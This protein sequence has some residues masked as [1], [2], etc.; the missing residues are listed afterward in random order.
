MAPAACTYFLRTNAK[1]TWR[2]KNVFVAASY[3]R[4]ITHLPYKV[5]SFA[6]YHH[7]KTL[8]IHIFFFTLHIFFLFSPYLT[9]SRVQ[10]A[11]MQEFVDTSPH[12]RRM[13]TYAP[14]PSIA[15]T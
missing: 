15:G 14:S 3:A 4:R 5:K 13:G 9:L 2:Q 8:S 10:V 7:H 1:T 6:S 12:K 11:R